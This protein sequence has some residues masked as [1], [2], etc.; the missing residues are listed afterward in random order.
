MA[1][2]YYV[3]IMYTQNKTYYCIAIRKQWKSIMNEDRVMY[4]SLCI[5]IDTAYQ[6]IIQK[7]LNL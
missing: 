7:V 1:M 5:N 3:I 4:K 2:L 6:Y